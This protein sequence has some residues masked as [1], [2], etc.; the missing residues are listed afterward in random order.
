MFPPISGAA[1]AEEELTPEV[2]DASESE[3]NEDVAEEAVVTESV[4]KRK[5]KRRR[6]CI[7]RVPLVP[8]ASRHRFLVFPAEET[9]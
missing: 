9:L 3:G 1:S 6:V 5:V 4:P 7:A 2:S 8:L